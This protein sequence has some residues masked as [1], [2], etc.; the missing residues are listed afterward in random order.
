MHVR[1]D[2]DPVHRCRWQPLLELGPVRA[3]VE[4]VVE[5]ASRARKQHAVTIRVCGHRKHV[6]QRISGR[7]VAVDVAPVLA[8]VRRHEEVRR[9]VVVAGKPE[10]HGDVHG[11]CVKVR[12]RD[13]VDLAAGRQMQISRDIDPL[14]L[15]RGFGA[16][17]IP[18]PAVVGASPQQAFLDGRKS[19]RPD[20]LANRLAEIVRRHPDAADEIL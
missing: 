16:C 7:N 4:R 9:I 19:Q 1:L 15:G 11:A 18:K 17:R 8:E 2:V 5:S 13:L 20:C 6:I 3:V 12:R 10:I 14:G